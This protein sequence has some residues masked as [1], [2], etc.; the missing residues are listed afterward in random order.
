MKDFLGKIQKDLKHLQAT[1]EQEGNDLLKRAKQ[2]VDEIKKKN[3]VSA[4]TRD[5]EKLIEDKFSKFEPA[6]YKFIGQVSKNAARYGLDVKDFEKMVKTGVK[7]A[8]I[9]LTSLKKAGRSSSS[10]STSKGKSSGV[11]GSRKGSKTTKS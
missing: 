8:K 11:K 2:T 10:S 5:L 9:G 3:N 1:I 4:R 6:L 7:K